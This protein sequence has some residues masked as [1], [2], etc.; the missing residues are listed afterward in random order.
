MWSHVKRLVIGVPWAFKTRV[1]V[2]EKTTN[3]M[4]INQY[5][6]PRAKNLRRGESREASQQLQE[7][8]WQ[9]QGNREGT[10][11]K[12]HASI[13]C[14]TKKG[15]MYKQLIPVHLNGPAPSK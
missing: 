4:W 6:N 9:G 2:E 12:R 14:F 5:Q 8:W 7:P 15:V 11:P 3:V 1:K 10:N 13:F